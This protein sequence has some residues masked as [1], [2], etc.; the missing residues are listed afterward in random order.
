MP[1]RY[2]IKH[3]T[4]YRYARPVTFG[5]HPAAKRVGDLERAI[6]ITLFDEPADVVPI[7]VDLPRLK[8]QL[9]VG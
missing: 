3:T 6:G 8:R 4:T 5:E 2:D 1:V 7:E 9:Q